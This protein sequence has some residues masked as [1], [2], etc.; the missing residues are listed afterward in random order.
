MLETEIDETKR[1]MILRFIDEPGWMALISSDGEG[2]LCQCR[3]ESRGCRCG[4]LHIGGRS[5]P[6][7]ADDSDMIYR[8]KAHQR[9]DQRS[10]MDGST[11]HSKVAWKTDIGHSNFDHSIAVRY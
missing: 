3:C 1:R 9:L 6:Y 5:S 8:R 7:T 2:R 4:T 10:R 11:D